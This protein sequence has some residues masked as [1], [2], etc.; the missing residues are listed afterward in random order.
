[1]GVGCTLW[2]WRQQTKSP[3]EWEEGRRKAR[4]PF[5]KPEGYYAE[6][7]VVAEETYHRNSRGVEL[8]AKRWQPADGAVRGMVVYCHGYADTCAYHFEAVAVCLAQS[9]F[10]VY[11]MDYEGHGSSQGLHAYIPSFNTIV[12]DV[13]EFTEALRNVP[14]LSPLPLHLLGESMGGAVAIKAHW[15]RPHGF[16]GAVLMSPMCKIS[17]AMMPPPPVVESVKV[18][19]ALLP[20]LK[21]VPS[22]DISETGLRDP[23]NRQKS[24]QNPVALPGPARLRTAVELLRATQE[25][26]PNMDKVSLPCLIMHGSDDLVT[27]PALSRDLYEAASSTDK[28][29]KMYEGSWHGLTSGEPDDVIAVVIKDIVDWISARSS[30]DSVKLNEIPKEALVPPFFVLS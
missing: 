2:V 18:L 28:T 21:A 15:R 24:Q 25:I 7:N 23:A 4:R 9:G 6:R 22:K 5:L 17:S 3:V 14:H 11:G 27:D 29:L 30:A 20:R 13:V 8:F 16:R 19:S 10:L 1:M 26:G 12:D